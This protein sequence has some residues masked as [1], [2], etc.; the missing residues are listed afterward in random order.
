MIRRFVFL[1]LLALLALGLLVGCSGRGARKDAPRVLR[2]AEDSLS[3]WRWR[4]D[5]IDAV[6]GSL[7]Q[8]KGQLVQG[9]GTAIYA[10]WFDHGE[11]RVIHEEMNL[12]HLGSR[13]SRYY[14]ER[15]VP[16]LALESGMVPI[17]TTLALKRLE[18]AM[19]FDDFGRVVAATKTL[20]SL[21]TWVAGYEASAAV[22]HAQQLRMT[23]QAAHSSRGAVAPPQG[24]L[25]A[26]Q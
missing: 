6:L 26:K 25:P 16:R 9:G 22:G 12:G 8:V 19:L 7:E 1:A 21:K 23:A 5:S 18:R 14:F 13:S 24:G 15:G 20:D 3:Y 17:D 11:V 10:A 4:A 2:T